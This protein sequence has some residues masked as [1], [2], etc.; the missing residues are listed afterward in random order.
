MLDVEYAP[1]L[2]QNLPF[3][4]EYRNHVR[5]RDLPNPRRSTTANITELGTTQ[6]IQRKKQKTCDTAGCVQ[7]HGD[8]CT[9]NTQEGASYWKNKA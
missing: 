3:N 6:Q 8:T 1:N 7:K 4:D 2:Q 9:K 5:A